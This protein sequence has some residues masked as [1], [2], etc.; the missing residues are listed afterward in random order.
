MDEMTSNWKRTEYES[1]EEA[2]H[3]LAPAV[4]QQSVRVAA[5]TQAIYVQ[6]CELGFGKDTRES[7]ERMKGKYADLAYKCGM[8][9]Q[10]GKALVP[11]EYQI[12]NDAFTDEEKAVYKKYTSDGRILAATLQELGD[13]PRGRKKG[14][15]CRTAHKEYPLAYDKG[16]LRTAYGTL[17]RK[18]LSCKE[19]NRCHKPHCTDSRSC[20]GT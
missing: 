18:R 10:L 13:K 16:K 14:R 20:K 3:G 7:A 5:Y 8:Y 2:F 15:I 4:R 12:W 9:H 17:G 11:P 6:A 19:K 1:W